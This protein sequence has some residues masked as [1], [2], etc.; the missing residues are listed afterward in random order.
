MLYL[1]RWLLQVVL[2]VA[3]VGTALAYVEGQSPVAGLVVTV[4]VAALLIAH[5]ETLRR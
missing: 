1:P 2:L 5:P 4:Y 3:L